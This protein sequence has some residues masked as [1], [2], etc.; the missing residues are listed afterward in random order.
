MHLKLIGGQLSLAHN[1]KVR[2]DM[3]E[4][5]R[6]TAGV[7]GVSPVGGK[8]KELWRKRFVEKMSFES[9]VEVRRSNGW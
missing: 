8:V 3:P 6:K 7:R 5:K 1:A 2:T 9:G 4:K